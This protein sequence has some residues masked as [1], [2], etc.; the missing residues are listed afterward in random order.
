MSTPTVNGAGPATGEGVKPDRL[1]TALGWASVGLGAPLSIA[2]EATLEAIGIEPDARSRAIAL[3]V[4][5]QEYTAAAGILAIER[6]RPVFSLWSRVVG[7]LAHLGLLTAA[8]RTQRQSAPRLAGAIAFVAGCAVIDTFA[9][10]RFSREPERQQAPADIHV[11]ASI[12]VRAPRERVYSYWQDF[13]NFPEFMLHLESVETT[14]ERRSHW[15]A[16]GPAGKSVEWDAETTEERPNELIAW[17][18]L[19]GADVENSGSV[20]FVDAPGGR[21]TEIHLELR[22][23]TPGGR[24]G[25]LA[26]RLF[27]EEPDSQARDD[28]RRFKQVMETGEVVRSD[29]TVEGQ[30]TARL[31][32]QRPAQPPEEEVRDASADRAGTGAEGSQ[33]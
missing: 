33:S 26:A 24:A 23:K 10:V 13:G 28:L 9:A 22:A 3:G 7:D 31:L 16:K 18:S 15:K 1:G 25:Q 14:G 19:E 29:G 30:S 6:P 2:P 20:R 11:R 32:K 21:G 12:T 5:V 8:W 4:G 27:G 17:R